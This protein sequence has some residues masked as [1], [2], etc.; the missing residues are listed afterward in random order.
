MKDI[1][2][3]TEECPRTSSI[4]M[5]IDRFLR[6]FIIRDLNQDFE[7]KNEYEKY[8]RKM[9]YDSHIEP[10]Y[11]HFPYGTKVFSFLF[12]YEFVSYWLRVF[13]IHNVYILGV[14]G[15]SSFG[16][17][18][19]YVCDYD[20]RILFQ[21]FPSPN[22]IPLMIIEETKTSDKESR[23]TG[24]YQRAI[25]FAYA[26]KFYPKDKLH[27]YMLY[28]NEH[29]PD[30]SN[31]TATNIFGTNLLLTLGVT[32]L[33]KEPYMSNY[34]RFNTIEE[35]ISAKNSMPLP[36]YGQ[37]IRINYDKTQGIIFIS[38]RLVKNNSISHDPNIGTVV[39]IAATIRELGYDKRIVI[40]D[41]QI[42]SQM[43]DNIK[44]NKFIFS[45][46]LYNLE[47]QGLQI[48]SI[49]LPVNYWTYENQSEKIA[50]IYLHVLAEKYGCTILYHNHAGCER[51]YFLT[52][53]PKYIA[54]PKKTEDDEKILIPDL[55]V[56]ANNMVTIIEGK[57]LDTLSE[58][59]NEVDSYDIF[60]NN[61]INS[62]D[63]GYPGI[64]IY[65]ALTIYGGELQE[66]PHERVLLYINNA[67]KI[68]VN[69]EA[70]YPWD[71]IFK[72]EGLMDLERN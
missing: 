9:Y 30:H 6:D 63:Y 59:L 31:P 52:N 45:C 4:C 41:H 2:L 66:L 13:D 32:I 1:Y 16:D 72:E 69:P 25:K 36:R 43:I 47:L 3:L 50:S 34:H 11:S 40:T 15:E 7:K 21:R 64:N 33:G 20:P 28:N 23:N 27:L 35:L 39:S 26:K 48:P 8:I 61:Y 58:G 57:K 42:C 19:L 17:Y 65:R 51:S 29:N 49:Q 55:I 54:I 56:K 46:I 5:I 44:G 12:K 62:K 24:V 10:Q 53:E 70:Q 37:P 60:E 22:D 71:I 38:C 67:G 18:L 14:T 68:I